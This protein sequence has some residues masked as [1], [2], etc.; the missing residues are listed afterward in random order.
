[1]II[2]TIWWFILWAELLEWIMVVK[3]HNSTNLFKLTGNKIQ[4]YIFILGV[5]YSQSLWGKINN[6]SHDFL[7]ILLKRIENGGVKR[8]ILCM[9]KIGNVTKNSCNIHEQRSRVKIWVSDYSLEQFNLCMLLF[10]LTRVSWQQHYMIIRQYVEC[11]CTDAVRS[12]LC[13]A[14]N[15]I[16]CVSW[17][18]NYKITL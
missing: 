17:S 8:K 11:L 14:A 6:W 15:W 1:M 2:Q 3:I 12:N 10:L 5:F 13:F 9:L 4:L 16:L 7:L 18:I